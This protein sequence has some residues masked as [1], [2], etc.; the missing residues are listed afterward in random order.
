M[1]EQ[2]K[3]M[4]ERQACELE[5]QVKLCVKLDGMKKVD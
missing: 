2:W 5:K 1:V 4:F 3:Q